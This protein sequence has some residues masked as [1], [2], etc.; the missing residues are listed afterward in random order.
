MQHASEVGGVVGEKPAQSA[1]LATEAPPAHGEMRRGTAKAIQRTG[2][3]TAGYRQLHS[4]YQ[5]FEFKNWL[6]ELGGEAVV[7]GF[8]RQVG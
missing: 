4:L 5:H 8:I 6:R 2:P 7:V 1:R 3:A